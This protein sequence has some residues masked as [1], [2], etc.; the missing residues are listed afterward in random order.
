VP[1]LPDLAAYVQAIRREVVAHSI[2]ALRIKSPFV[3]RSLDLEREACIDQPVLDVQR[4]GK[5]IVLVLPR[6]RYL[7]FHLMIAGRF[8]WSVPATDATKKHD[9]LAVRFDRGALLLREVATKKRASLHIV[10]GQ[11]KLAA[12]DRGGLELLECSFA[13][14]SK[15]LRAS[16]QTLKRWLTD[17]GQVSGV[18][19]AYSDEI[20]CAAGLSPFLRTGQLDGEQQQRLFDACRAT[21]SLWVERLLAQ[22]GDRFPDK[23]TPFREG[24]LVHGRY[25]QPCG[26]CGAPVQR[27]VYSERE[28]H[29][30]PRCQTEGRVLAD[31]SLSRLLKGEWPPRF[32][33]DDA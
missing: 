22:S 15:R 13:S 21:L 29:Y 8:F 5:Q 30:C 32:D 26:R 19:N 9:L 31:R 11:N 17:P 27:I 1:E 18:G 2:R 20:L 25:R 14:F 10:C 7:I 3:L 24:M 33:E 28:F 12:F 23:V 6:E 4:L 16:N